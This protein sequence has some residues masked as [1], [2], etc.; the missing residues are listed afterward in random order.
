MST[1]H[2]KQRFFVSF[3]LLSLLSGLTIGMNKILIT[4]L[5][6]SL[7]AE[8]W[9]LGLI[10][11]AESLA[12][13]A[14]TLPA[15]LLIG[16]YSPRLGYLAASLL[17]TLLYLTLAQVQHWLQLAFLMILCGICIAF[18]IVAMSSSFL[19]RLPEIGTHRAGWYK[20]TLSLGTMALG[21]LAGHSLSHAF[22][23]DG[24]LGTSAGLFAAMALLGWFTLPDSPR[25]SAPDP[26][27]S[28]WLAALWSNRSVREACLFEGLG[29]SLFA[30]Y[31]TFMLVI[32]IKELHWSQSEGVALL[33]TSGAAYVSVLLGLGQPLRRLGEARAYRLSHSLLF[34]GALLLACSAWQ[35]LLFLGALAL[36]TGIGGNHLV[37]VTRVALSP[38]NKSHVSGLMTLCQ[39]AGSS[40]GAIVGGWL[41]AW[42]GLQPVFLVLAL[43]WLIRVLATLLAAPATPAILNHLESDN[44]RIE[45]SSPEPDAR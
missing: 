25:R 11:G 13:A 8:S 14:V 31:S 12:M 23:L 32:A 22:S 40:T 15:G 41:G 3:I 20:G 28:H 7:D 21:P 17:L 42:L 27:R 16:R 26:S 44:E 10:S 5:G 18:R 2:N 45:S 33:I 30:F 37:N 43:P 6:L 4:L 29:G 24:A 34:G 36:G 1:G 39:M 19:Q 35:P 9:Q 38:V